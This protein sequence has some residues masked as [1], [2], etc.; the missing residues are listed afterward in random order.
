[1]HQG[2]NV[3]HILVWVTAATALTLLISTAAAIGIGGRQSLL[4][5]AIGVPA[6]WSWVARLPWLLLALTAGMVAL[7][8]R[9]LNQ[10][11][12]LSRLLLLSGMAGAVSVVALWA[13]LSAA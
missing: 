1:M 10:T 2:Q 12:R 7:T 8:S 5:P 9:R 4:L 11:D 13:Y 6:G 3:Q